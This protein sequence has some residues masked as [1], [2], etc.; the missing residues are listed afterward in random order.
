LPLAAL[1]QVPAQRVDWLVPGLLKEKVI[2]LLKTL[3]QKYR[4]RLQPLDGFAESFCDADPDRDEPLLRALTR[5]VEEKIALKLPLD[6]FRPGEL[7]PHLLMNFRLQDEHGG[8]LAIS[9]NLAELRAQYGDRVTESFVRA[10][11][12]HEE[13]EGELAGLT[14]WSFGPLPDLLEVKVGGRSIAGFPALVDEGDSVAL[15]A[16]DTEDKAAQMHRQGLTRLFALA[17]KEQLRFIDRSLPRELGMQFMALGTEKELKE[18]IIAATIERSCL[19]EPEPT[20]AA[21]FEARVAAAKGRV[22][23]VAQE[24]GRLAGTILAEYSALQ[25]RLAGAQKAF[26]AACADIGEQLAGL[27]HKR[28][29][30]ALAYE[31]LTQLPRYLKAAALRLD[32]ARADAARDT[33]LLA[34]WQALAKPWQREFAA[35]RKAGVDDPFLEEFRWL[36]EELRV[37]LFAQELKTPSPVSVK[38]LQKMWEGRPRT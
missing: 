11:V 14:S 35:M 6:G 2:A 18:Q 10:E 33:R 25:K 16:F 22:V 17:L 24:I 5:A 32:K 34:D 36:L 37:A 31:R 27:M 29:I 9:R 19:G 26:P 12:K 8:T 28:F 3:P 20:D 4:H 15:R 1:N 23:L 21:A 13:A 7:R 30:A 38:R